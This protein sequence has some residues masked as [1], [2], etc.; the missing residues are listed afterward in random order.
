MEFFTINRSLTIE[1]DKKA[2]AKSGSKNSILV[3]FAFIGKLAQLV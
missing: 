2:G 3:N 1:W